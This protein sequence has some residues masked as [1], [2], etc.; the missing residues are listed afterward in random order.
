MKY[1]QQGNG[2]YL[3]LVHGAL[4]DG[5]MWHKHMAL[6]AP[7]FELVSVTL[8]HFDE[9]DTGGFGLNTHA[10][11]LAALVNE[12]ARHKPV[13]I[14]GWSYGADVVLNA[15][16]KQDFPVSGVF[17]YEPGYPGCLQ[18]SELNTWQQDAN[19]MFGQ[20]FEE[21][22]HG[23]LEQAVASLIDGSGNKQGYFQSQPCSVQ[24]AQLAKRHTLAHQLHQQEHPLINPD[25]VANISVPVVLGY[26]EHTRPLFR[27]VTARTSA[28]INQAELQEMSGESHMLP[29]ENPEKFSDHIKSIFL[30]QG[31]QR[32]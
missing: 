16:A 12:L 5:A 15:L 8:R 20:V 11:E 13:K 18:E 26:G 14:V 27:L 30:P 3:V 1:T 9:G 19:A 6:L 23:N 4:A 17:L 2:D 22:S 32:S 31:Q 28:L 24:E 10:D 7:Y 21:F 29:Q 25:T